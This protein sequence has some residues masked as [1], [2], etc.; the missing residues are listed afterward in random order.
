MEPLEKLEMIVKGTLAQKK[1]D[2]EM[3][4]YKASNLYVLGLDHEI[5]TLQSVLCEID[6]I[7]RN[8]PTKSDEMVLKMYPPDQ[9]K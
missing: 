7:K 6:A 4:R 1:K 9:W 3:S 5:S 8:A 2:Y